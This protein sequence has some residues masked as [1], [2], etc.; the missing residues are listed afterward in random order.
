M[1][2]YTFHSLIGFLLVCSP[3]IFS[4]YQLKWEDVFS[5]GQNSNEECIGTGFDNEGNYYIV[6]RADNG[7]NYYDFMVVKYNTNGDTLWTR[8]Y[9]INANNAATAT[10]FYI[11]SVGNSYILGFSGHESGNQPFD[12]VTIK[13]NKNGDMQFS[14]LYDANLFFPNPSSIAVDNSGN[15]YVSADD[16]SLVLIKYNSDGSEGWIK[17][18]PVQTSLH[19][20]K[21]LIDN[22]GN[23]LVAGN[24]TNASNGFQ[25][26]FLMK[27]NSSGDTVWTRTYDRTGYDDYLYSLSVDDQNNIFLGGSAQYAQSYITEDFAVVKYN[28][29]GVFQWERFY[30]GFYDNR[31]QIVDLA[32]DET[33]NVFAAG[34]SYDDSFLSTAMVIKY[35]P[36]GDSL[37][38]I[39]FNGDTSGSSLGKVGLYK[40]AGSPDARITGIR[41]YLNYLIFYGISFN[42]IATYPIF[43]ILLN[44]NELLVEATIFYVAQ[45]YDFF[46]ALAILSQLGLN[47]TVNTVAGLPEIIITGNAQTTLPPLSFKFATAKFSSGTVDVE[48]E[49]KAVS[50]FV[51]HQNYPNPFNPTTTI[52]WQSQVSGWQTLKVYDLLG[53]EVVT[54]VDEYKAAGV[55][56]IKFNAANLSSGMYFYTLTT[57]NFTQSKKLL[58]MK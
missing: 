11:D 26:F 32:T 38:S 57:G 4:Q 9:D 5:S 42:G 29:D 14:N 25:D 36:A 28:S 3:L 18:Y 27:Y 45:N 33:G 2:R 21:I 6:G 13:Y 8:M 43:S 44:K 40:T 10:D 31:D 35:S 46:T 23:I 16:D 39:S 17:K 51:L 58:L 41:N 49:Q 15:V 34:N 48:P 56:S 24:I 22:T 1:R 55:Y 52:K 50:E 54:L 12:V 19:S 37:W 7:V 47:K 30:N 20:E 53:R